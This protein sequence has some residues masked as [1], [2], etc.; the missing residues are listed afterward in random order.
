M[1]KILIADDHAIIR[2]GFKQIVADQADMMVVGEAQNACEAL[3]L[4]RKMAWDVLVLDVNMPDRSGLEVL[5]DLKHFQRALP[6]SRSRQCNCFDSGG[7][8]MTEPSAI[9][10][11]ASSQLPPAIGLTVATGGRRKPPC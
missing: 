11:V 1:I 10:T 4:A 6:V 9:V 3:H 2:Q 5:E 8:R 7:V